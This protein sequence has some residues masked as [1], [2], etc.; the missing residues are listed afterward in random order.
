[1]GVPAG[2]GAAGYHCSECLRPTLIPAPTVPEL[3]THTGP[4]CLARCRLRVPYVTHTPGPHVLPAPREPTSGPR[5]ARPLRS[6]GGWPASSLPASRQGREPGAAAWAGPRVCRG[7][8]GTNLPNV[9]GGAGGCPST[10]GTAGGA[11]GHGPETQVQVPAPLL[12]PGL[13]PAS[14]SSAG[15]GRGSDATS[16]DPG[17]ES[18][19]KHLPRIWAL[20]TVTGSTH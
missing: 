2:A 1:M 6:S 12:T 13:P 3:P 7:S 20:M 5:G 18:A 19:R 14:P 4:R 11:G 16:Q 8:A 9:G 15:G 17:G 10:R